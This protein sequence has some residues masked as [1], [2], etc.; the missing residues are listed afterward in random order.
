MPQITLSPAVY[1]SA[2]LP[3]L[4]A[5]PGCYQWIIKCEVYNLRSGEFT[6]P[7]QG[8]PEGLRERELI[9]SVLELDT[10]SKSQS[11]G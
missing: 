10:T 7:W 8:L 4:G 6:N 1:E 2:H 9:S 11:K 3:Q 5:S